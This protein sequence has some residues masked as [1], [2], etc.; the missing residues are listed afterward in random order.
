MPTLSPE[1]RAAYASSPRLLLDHLTVRDLRLSATFDTPQQAFERA[2][3]TVHYWRSAAPAS[4]NDFTEVVFE[5]PAS[6]LWFASRIN[7]IGTADH[8]RPDA[9]LAFLENAIERS[10]SRPNNTDPNVSSLTALIRCAAAQASRS[11]GSKT[12]EAWAAGAVLL[13]CLSVLDATAPASE[14]AAMRTVLALTDPDLLGQ[15]ERLATWQSNVTN[16]VSAADDAA[17]DAY[18]QAMRTMWPAFGAT[19]DIAAHD[20]KTDLLLSY[21]RE[22]WPVRAAEIA[23]AALASARIDPHAMSYVI[24]PFVDAWQRGLINK[25]SI[26]AGRPFT[27]Q[28]LLDMAVVPDGVRT[29]EAA[30]PVALP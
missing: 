23:L 10:L 6:G 18:A 14:I 30:A 17:M 13:G 1:T 9:V 15:V 27:V 25:D 2:G 19:S 4:V 8:G 24:R 29:P 12:G 7:M 11:D 16:G 3:L 21:P 20:L 28:A 26:V 22:D 5:H